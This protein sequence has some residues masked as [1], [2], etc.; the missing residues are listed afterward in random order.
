MLT[1]IRGAL[2]L[3][4]LLSPVLLALAVFIATSIAIGDIREAT[5][6]YSAEMAARVDAIE[7]DFSAA[8]EGLETIGTFV[9]KTRDAVAA[10]AEALKALTDRIEIPLPRIPVI[11]FDIPDIDFRV[12]GVT[13]LKALGADLAE[14][15]RAVGAEI[16][17]VD[18]DGRP[19]TTI[20]V[21]IAHRSRP[22]CLCAGR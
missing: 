22:F 8:S 9:G 5:D 6:N 15:G 12:P 7:L 13:Q 3:V 2:I 11:N 17:A 1:R 16:A 10:Q 4:R 18:G 14:A 20:V 21:E 19:D